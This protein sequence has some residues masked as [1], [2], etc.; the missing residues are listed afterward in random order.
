MKHPG[1]ECMQ[2]DIGGTL[3]TTKQAGV[4]ISL[5]GKCMRPG[6]HG[7]RLRIQHSD[8][9]ALLRFEPV[10]EKARDSGFQFRP[11]SAQGHCQ[12]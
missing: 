6:L 5:P 7:A 3:C 1:Q 10:A 2:K 12:D 8:T 9:E 11:Q 4:G